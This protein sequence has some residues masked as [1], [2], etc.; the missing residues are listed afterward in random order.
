MYIFKIIV[1]NTLHLSFW[2]IGAGTLEFVN[3]ESLE[4][5]RA[6]VVGGDIVVGVD[7]EVGL[8]LTGSV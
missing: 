3:I 7:L 8:V 4:V 1:L 2:M 5:D 6:I